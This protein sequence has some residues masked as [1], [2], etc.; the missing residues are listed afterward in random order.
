MKKI[1]LTLATLMVVG[2]GLKA[3]TIDPLRDLHNHLRSKFGGLNKPNPVK[4]YQYDMV[5]HTTDKAKW[6]NINSTT[7]INTDEWYRMYQETYF[8]AFDTL[9]LQTDEDI[10]HLFFLLHW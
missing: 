2:G 1:L 7:F 6:T 4:E 5:G 9:P 3:Q 8:M 10:L